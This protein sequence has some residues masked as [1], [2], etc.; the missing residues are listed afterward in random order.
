MCRYCW[1]K[2]LIIRIF[3]ILIVSRKLLANLCVR[4]TKDSRDLSK[5][6]NVDKIQIHGFKKKK[7]KK[8]IQTRLLKKN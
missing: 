2:A 4:Q 1:V 7:K 6:L 3:V 5:Y 8:K